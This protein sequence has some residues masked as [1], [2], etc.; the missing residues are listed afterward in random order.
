MYEA[1]KACSLD[2]LSVIPCTRVETPFGGSPR[3]PGLAPWSGGFCC[4][5]RGGGRGDGASGEKGGGREGQGEG[6]ARAT[7]P[8]AEH[9]GEGAGETLRGGYASR[10]GSRVLR[11]SGIVAN[12]IGSAAVNSAVVTLL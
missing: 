8:A 4:Y 12:S 7:S 2:P 9:G 10:A 1:N 6:R 5:L 11:T 3:V